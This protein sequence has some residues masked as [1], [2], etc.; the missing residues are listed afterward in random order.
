MGCRAALADFDGDGQLDAATASGRVSIFHG[1]GD[2]TL[3]APL[4]YAI[5]GSESIVTGDFNGDGRPDIATVGGSPATLSV[6]LNRD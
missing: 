4:S 1:R 5:A 6:L 2:G 3:S